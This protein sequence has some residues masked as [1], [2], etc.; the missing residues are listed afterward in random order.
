MKLILYYLALLVFIAVVAGFLISQNSAANT[1]DM[2]AVL[3]VC[4]LLGGYTVAMSLVGEGKTEDEREQH[5]R[6]VA[7]RWALIAGTA[8]L[9][10]GIIYQLMV[11][12]SLNY[13]LL[14]GLVAINLTKIISF[15]YLNYKK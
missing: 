1:M 12:H 7:N 5:H 11:Q 13:W 4:V 6:F 3:W 2:T 14:I 8:T 15:I 10:I 9:S